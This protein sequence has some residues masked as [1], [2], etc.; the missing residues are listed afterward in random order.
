MASDV[1]I[2]NS[3][4]IK[5][6][7]GAAGRITSLT[8]GS[9]N[10]NYCNEQFAKIREQLLR[11]HLWN[12]AKERG[13]LAQLGTTPVSGFDFAYQ[14]PADFLRAVAVHDNDASR[15]TV[16]YE[17][18]ERT[19]LCDAN[20][21]WLIYVKK[22]TDPNQMDSMFRECFAYA[23]ARDLAV[24]I[25]GSQ[26]MQERM[27]ANLKTEIR[28]AKSAD[29]IEDW[30]EEFPESPWVSARGGISSGPWGEGA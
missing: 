10:A 6:G 28:E 26:P 14:L 30:P 1:G 25:T 21:V 13:K 4:L 3:A 20:E 29:A 15:G 18:K 2:C 9:P 7:V 12:F 22:V 5:L 11:K 17:V 24:A 16:R 27:R 23:L 19:L 8:E